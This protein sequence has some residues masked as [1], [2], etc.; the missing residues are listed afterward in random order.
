M[1]WRFWLPVFQN[2]GVRFGSR[3]KACRRQQQTSPR[4]QRRAQPEMRPVRCPWSFWDGL[5][6]ASGTFEDSFCC[7]LAE[8]YLL[9][10]G[11]PQ[12][13]P[14]KVSDLSSSRI[15]TLAVLLGA[16]QPACGIIGE[17]TESE[18]RRSRHQPVQHN[19]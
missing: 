3:R 10:D 14:L 1:A 2:R 11:S 4:N 13:V 6:V 8:P 15:T 5:R 17:I 16:W 7:W 18:R 19:E 9:N 12:P